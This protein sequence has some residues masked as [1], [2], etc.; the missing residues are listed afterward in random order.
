MV[1]DKRRLTDHVSLFRLRLRDGGS[2]PTWE[3]GA[4]IDVVL[5]PS[6]ERQY[7]L[8]GDPA[9]RDSWSIAVLREPESRGGSIQLHDEVAV[10]SELTVRGPRNQF[11]LV[12]ADSYLFIAG[13]IGITPLLPMIR[14]LRASGGDWRLVYG[15]QRMSSMAFTE[16][17]ADEE[18]RITLWPQDECGLIDVDVLLRDLPATTKVY[19]CGPGALID[20]IE[21]RCVGT[22]GVLHVER[23]RA[24]EGA[25]GARTGSFQ[26]RLEYSDLTVAVAEGQTIAEAMEDAGLETMTSCRE[27]TCGTCETAVLEGVPDHRD[28]LLSE[29]EK[30]A[31]D[32]MMI[33][34]SRSLTPVL[35]LD[36]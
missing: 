1:D 2:F 19:C 15:G 26:V 4:H 29:E 17:F 6:M 7:S 3:P 24:Q 21:Q 16:E 5:S 8:C 25:L 27:G 18:D 36:L 28:S 11:P 20:A 9:D 14:S 32:T 12:A 34:C 33:C 23:F 22:P 35:V 31:N 10:G 13:G 30:A